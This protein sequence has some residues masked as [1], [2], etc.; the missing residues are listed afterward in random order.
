MKKYLLCLAL[1]IF[2]SL[3]GMATA[4]KVSAANVINEETKEE[5]I[6]EVGNMYAVFNGGYGSNY[7]YHLKNHISVTVIS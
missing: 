7:L 2:S 5:L 1:F 6:I 3:I 4:I